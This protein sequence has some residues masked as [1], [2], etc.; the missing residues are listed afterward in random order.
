MKERVKLPSPLKGYLCRVSI[1]GSLNLN[2]CKQ[3]Y[4]FVEKEIA[5][6]YGTEYYTVNKEIVVAYNIEI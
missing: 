1:R 5:G 4:L 2:T 3:I 6:I